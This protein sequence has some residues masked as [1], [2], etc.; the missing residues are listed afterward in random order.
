MFAHKFKSI[1]VFL[2]IFSIRFLFCIVVG[3]F[4]LFAVPFI[5][6]TTTDNLNTL[7]GYYIV[8]RID[9]DLL[10]FYS[11]AQEL[12]VYGA[13]NEVLAKRVVIVARIGEVVFLWVCPALGIIWG[14]SQSRFLERI[15]V[16]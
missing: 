5:F 15:F 1:F 4:L 9:G 3:W 13:D 16:T 10:E 7:E 14:F 6:C 11:I 8:E 2:V 12:E